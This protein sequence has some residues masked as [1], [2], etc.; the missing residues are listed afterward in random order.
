MTEAEKAWT[1]SQGP[2]PKKRLDGFPTRSDQ[3]YWSK[4]EKV[5]QSATTRAVTSA[6]ASIN[7]QADAAATAG[8]LARGKPRSVRNDE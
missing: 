6:F 5:I 3:R 8:P 4:A 1:P 7:T 2:R